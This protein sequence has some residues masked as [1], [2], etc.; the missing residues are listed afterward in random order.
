M[1]LPDLIVWARR[2]TNYLANPLYFISFKI[3]MY[4]RRKF[5]S[6][7]I[8]IDNNNNQPSSSKNSSK[9]E[10]NAINKYQS[11]VNNK[12]QNFVDRSNKQKQKFSQST[13]TPERKQRESKPLKREH[14]K[15]VLSQDN[16]TLEIKHPQLE[17]PF[18]LEEQEIRGRRGRYKCI[19]QILRDEERVRLYK[20]IHNQTNKSVLIKDYLL[21]DREYNR[22]ERQACKEKFA[23]IS[24]INI[25]NIEGQDFRV[26]TPLEVIVPP[27]EKR[28]YLVTE[29]INYSYSLKEYLEKKGALNS[30]QVVRILDQ[31]L[32]TLWFLHTQRVRLPTG[33]FQDGIAHGN[34]N[35]NSVLITLNEEGYGAF[36]EP[37]LF[38]YLSDLALWEH[39]FL[40]PN[41]PPI[42]SSFSQDLADLGVIGAQLISGEIW[43]NSNDNLSNKQRLEQWSFFDSALES[44]ILR[45]S[46]LNNRFESALASRNELLR[47]QQKGYFEEKDE[48]IAEE[49]NEWENKTPERKKERKRRFIT[50]PTAI[51]ILLGFIVGF[52]VVSLN[53][54]NYDNKT[55]DRDISCCF[56]DINLPRGKFSYAVEDSIWKYIIERSGFVS[57]NKSLKEE[58][59]IRKPQLRN[60]QFDDS[61]Q[62]AIK[63]LQKGEIDFVLGQWKENLPAELN[64]E[65]IA[66]HGLVVFVAFSDNQKKKNLPEAFNGQI[67]M[68]QL[69]SLYAQGELETLIP[70]DLKD[71]KLKLY[72]PFEFDAIKTF[73]ELVFEKNNNRE[74][75][76]FRNLTDRLLSQQ[77][78]KLY[79][80]KKFQHTTR[81]LLENVYVDFESNKTISI[82]F[83]FVNTVFGQC[84]VYP[85]AV[86]KD[87]RAIQPFASSNGEPIT[88]KTDLCDDKG[89]YWLN[90]EAFKTKQY[91]LGYSL[92]A[93]YPKEGKRSHAGKQFA[94]L[95]KTD[96][97]Q[98]LL[99]ETG[100]VPIR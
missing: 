72:V 76:N 21:S 11:F 40:P 23:S 16:N 41:S 5:S 22:E 100:L 43:E 59:L 42:K 20:G 88:P 68:E 82:G 55:Q 15:E 27:R 48:E 32:Q 39:L 17:I 61:K 10:Q 4:F 49:E 8:P 85:L 69:Q 51:V 62:N 81:K 93:I 64:Q 46:G 77:I 29:Y 6:F 33:T 60:Y 9:T 54:L 34:L 44:F 94:E 53:S 1:R 30:K 96:E 18:L 24:N 70:K 80:Q 35:L 99:R 12:Y 65:I 58:L 90:T 95:L 92:V 38:V 56:A 26:I 86:E 47:L 50:L 28:C 79:K 87:G 73:E 31:A 3:S 63:A 36:D 52:F 57:Q 19:G 78:E 14:Q 13:L 83:S 2:Q 45:L 7:E 74:K 66:Y 84:A 25:R 91:P 89:G 98:Y 97:G 75:D 71:W 37:Q 67:S